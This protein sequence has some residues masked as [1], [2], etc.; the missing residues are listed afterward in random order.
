MSP[1][2]EPEPRNERIEREMKRICIPEN[3]I[4]FQDNKKMTK[5]G[6]IAECLDLQI[7]IGESAN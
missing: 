5:K 2:V 7:P 1:F 6:Q 3:T 4:C